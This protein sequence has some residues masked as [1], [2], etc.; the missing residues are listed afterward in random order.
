ML[1]SIGKDR[2]ID[3]TFDD[4]S[5]LQRHGTSVPRL[6]STFPASW[7]AGDELTPLF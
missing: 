4:M 5:L 1:L 3:K 7:K 2:L 6:N